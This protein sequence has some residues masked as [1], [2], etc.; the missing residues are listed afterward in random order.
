MKT[1]TTF[2][3]ILF[4]QFLSL[5]NSPQSSRERIQTVARSIAERYKTRGHNG[6]RTRSSTF[7]LLIDLMYFF[8]LYHQKQ[9]DN[10]LDVSAVDI[11][12]NNILVDVGL[13][14]RVVVFFHFHSLKNERAIEVF[15]TGVK[16]RSSQPRARRDQS[17]LLFYKFSIAQCYGR[18]RNFLV[19]P[20]TFVSDISKLHFSVETKKRIAERTM[21]FFVS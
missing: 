14:I 2:H 18:V 8:D 7:Y 12:Y 11:L 9:N 4:F 17:D 19:A 3:I 15:S 13:F 16:A 20:I 10:A 6:T 5:A 1:S 21:A